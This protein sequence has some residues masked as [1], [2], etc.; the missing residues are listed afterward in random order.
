A[1]HPAARRA[2]LGRGE[3]E[4]RGD[5]FLHAAR[6]IRRMGRLGIEPRTYCLRVSC[7]ASRAIGPNGK[8]T[9]SNG[10]KQTR[11]ANTSRKGVTP[12]TM[13]VRSTY[14][15]ATSL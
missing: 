9:S 15:S 8:K 10:V 11:H 12:K 1:H 5:V 2:D 13:V 3:G 4:R 7:S 6:V 14:S